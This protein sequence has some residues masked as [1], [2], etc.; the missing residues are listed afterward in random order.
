MTYRNCKKLIEIKK[1]KG[2]MNQAWME[3]MK[4]KLDIFLLNSRIT[5]AEYA[6]LIQLLDGETEE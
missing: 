6:E 3:E 1:R 4:D 5:E 2:G